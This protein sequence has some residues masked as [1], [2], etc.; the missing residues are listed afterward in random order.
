[1]RG[2]REYYEV[3]QLSPKDAG[4]IVNDQ[5]TGLGCLLHGAV[6]MAM[7]VAIVIVCMELASEEHVSKE[8]WLAIGGFCFI[9]VAF[10]VS[11][12]AYEQWKLRKAV[13]G[14]NLI[15]LRGTVQ[16]FESERIQVHNGQ[17]RLNNK[18]SY[19]IIEVDTPHDHQK[20]FLISEPER[21]AFSVGQPVELKYVDSNGQ[22]VFLQPIRGVKQ[23]LTPHDRML[24]K[25]HHNQTFGDLRLMSGYYI[26]YV[27]FL[28]L[29]LAGLSLYF[30]IWTKY[31]VV[32]AMF[33]GMLYY[34]M[35]VLLM[36]GKEGFLPMLDYKITFTGDVRNIR[37]HPNGLGFTV[38]LVDEYGYP[39]D[40]S[41]DRTQYTLV[42][43]VKTVSITYRPQE[44][45]QYEIQREQLLDVVV[46][47]R[48]S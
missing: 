7:V 33:L 16:K 32:L 14:A 5:K 31:I 43:D 48:E 44:T 10:F 4:R 28:G 39:Q 15:T 3:A 18:F 38:Q 23:P 41:I 19:L 17:A 12:T 24:L 29:V 8:T 9:F 36:V 46:L 11:I 22:C 6:L 35:H 2:Y 13:V 25:Q 40:V 45:H 20:R 30:G 37:A 27:F 26:R 1:M 42:K 34:L 21:N 47:T